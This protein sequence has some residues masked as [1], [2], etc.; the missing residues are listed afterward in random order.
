MVCTYEVMLAMRPAQKVAPK[1]PKT[2][3]YHVS[4]VSAGVDVPVPDRGVRG[5]G[6][7]QRP[8]VVL[9]AVVEHV[10]PDARPV[11]EDDRRQRYVDHNDGRRRDHAAAVRFHEAADAVDVRRQQ[12]GADEVRQPQHGPPADGEAE[13]VDG[14]RGEKVPPEPWRAQVP[15]GDA[16]PV[17]HHHLLAALHLGEGDGGVV[18]PHVGQEEGVDGV[19]DDD[20]RR[21]QHGRAAAAAAAVKLPAPVLALDA[22]RDGEREVAEGRDP[23]APEG[24]VERRVGVHDSGLLDLVGRDHHLA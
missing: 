4:L 23:G 1:V 3:A 6:P 8:Q 18:Q 24:E 13:N 2:M 21:P 15:G 14:Q 22:G 19:V 20:P 11:D 7:V 5:H 17:R 10:P 16:L 9:P 12:H